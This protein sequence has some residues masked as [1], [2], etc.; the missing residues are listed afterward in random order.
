MSYESCALQ[1]VFVV[2]WGKVPQVLDVDRYAKE[3][4]DASAKQG[5]H[6]VGLFIVPSDSSA[7]DDAFRKAQAKKLPEIMKS[8]SYAV[9]VFEGTGFISSLKRSALVGILLLAPKRYPIHVRSSVE[10]ALI[11]NPAGP[12]DFNPKLTLAELKRRNLC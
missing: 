2:R 10:E 9:A 7:P 8:L 4:A 6:L 12:I 11:L 3:M 5:K 1:G